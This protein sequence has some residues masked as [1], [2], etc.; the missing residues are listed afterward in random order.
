MSAVILMND[1]K[2]AICFIKASFTK[3]YKPNPSLL[4]PLKRDVSSTQLHMQRWYNRLWWTHSTLV[5]DS[6]K[7]G[8]T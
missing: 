7:R 1:K 3:R 2:V 8:R 6:Y 5:I 4:T